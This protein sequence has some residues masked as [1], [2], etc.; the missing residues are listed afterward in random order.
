MTE[1]TREEQWAKINQDIDAK[2]DDVRELRFRVVHGERELRDLMDERRRIIWPP[3]P[4]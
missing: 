1:M 3:K 2:A 4:A